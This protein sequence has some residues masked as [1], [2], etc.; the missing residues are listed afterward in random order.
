M[1]SKVAS[2]GVTATRTGSFKIAFASSAISLGIVAENS[3][4]CLLEGISLTILLTS[5]MNP[6]SSIRSASSSTKNLT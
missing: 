4:V 3:M 6:M 1:I 2:T 5:W